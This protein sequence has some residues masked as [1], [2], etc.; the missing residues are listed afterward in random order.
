[1]KSGNMTLLYTHQCIPRA[2]S[3]YGVLQHLVKTC[4]NK[5]V[6]IWMN[7][8][9]FYWIWNKCMWTNVLC[10]LTLKSKYSKASGFYYFKFEFGPILQKVFS[11]HFQEIIL[12]CYY[13]TSIFLKKFS[14]SSWHVILE[15]FIMIKCK[16]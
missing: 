1:M 15:M 11:R 14:C 2:R 12:M 3:M 6:N 13:F 10:D 4:F 16:R 9:V 7:G 5:W 8:L